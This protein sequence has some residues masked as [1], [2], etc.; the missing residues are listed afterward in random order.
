MLRAHELGVR[1]LRDRERGRR[2][3]VRRVRG[4]PRRAPRCP[5]PRPAR[6]PPGS[7]PRSLAHDRAGPGR[8]RSAE[9]AAGHGA[10]W[11][12]RHARRRSAPQR[13]RCR[14]DPKPRPAL[15]DRLPPPPRGRRSPAGGAGLGAADRRCSTAGGLRLGPEPGGPDRSRGAA[16]LASPT[17]DAGRAPAERVA[18]TAD[19][20]A[21]AATRRRPG[22]GVAWGGG[23][24]PPTGPS[25]APWA[26]V[27]AAG[28]CRVHAADRR[29]PGHRRRSPALAARRTGRGR[30]AGAG[31]TAPA[32]FAV[33]GGRDARCRR[34]GPSTLPRSRLV[35]DGSPMDRVASSPA[36]TAARAGAATTVTTSEDPHRRT[37]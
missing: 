35:D 29:D 16:D 22:R 6:A 2:V 10:A 15:H 26:G 24:R 34:M 18:P 27:R 31:R 11:G 3:L 4:R 32:R 5:G 1:A 25:A 21:L 7:A 30:R 13:H 36:G 9:R 19:V 20:D 28:S 14:V 23:P 8:R 17:R 37:W 33:S 12:G